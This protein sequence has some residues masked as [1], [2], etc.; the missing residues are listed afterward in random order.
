VNFRIRIEE[1][2]IEWDDIRI[3]EIIIE[4]DD[5]TTIKIGTNELTRIYDHI[6]DPE[7][8]CAAL[9]PIIG[10]RA[11]KKPPI[12]RVRTPRANDPPPN[13]GESEKDYLDRLTK[14]HTTRRRQLSK[15]TA[16]RPAQPRP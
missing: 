9:G 16:R 14:L 5:G 4:W 1:I 11:I 12:R 13:F 15:R 8:V 6:E 7:A 3:E 10:E 2:I